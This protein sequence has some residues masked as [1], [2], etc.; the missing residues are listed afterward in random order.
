MR[1]LERYNGTMK[2]HERAATKQC[3][4]CGKRKP[5]AAFYTSRKTHKC[6]QC[7]GKG[8]HLRYLRNRERVLERS[9]KR[10]VEKA[11]VI[12]RYLAAWYIRNRKHVLKRCRRYNER[13]EVIAREKERHRKR[14]LAMRDVLLKQRKALRTPEVLVKLR[15]YSKRHYRRNKLMYVE[16]CGRRRAIRIKACPVWANLTEIRRIYQRAA[17][18]TRATGIKHHV[19]HIVPL[20]GRNVCGLHVEQNLQVLSAKENLEKAFKFG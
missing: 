3:T 11:D 14:W 16:R 2:T 5:Q 18:L 10:R 8:S 6:K 9:A 17:E 7:E 13:P 12:K 1:E 20:Q 4:E 19:D 15:R